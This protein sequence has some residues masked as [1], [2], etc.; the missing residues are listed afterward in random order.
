MPPLA[1]NGVSKVKC[2][3]GGSQSESESELEPDVDEPDEELRQNRQPPHVELEREEEPC[4]EDREEPDVVVREDDEELDELDEDEPLRCDRA[5]LARRRPL[6]LTVRQALFTRLLAERLDLPE[7]PVL[8]AF[9]LLFRRRLRLRLGWTG[10]YR[11]CG[12][13]PSRTASCAA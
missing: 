7:R 11:G 6:R 2:G 12:V 13:R 1:R 3:V 10:V 5:A 9:D 4:V 8:E